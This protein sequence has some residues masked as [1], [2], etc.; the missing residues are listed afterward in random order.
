MRRH[1]IVTHVSI[2]GKGSCPPTRERESESER[3]GGG[4]GESEGES[5][6]ADVM[7]VGVAVLLAARVG[8]LDRLP[9]PVSMETE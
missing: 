7:P 6:R 2:R 5:P 8:R 4:E 1:Q 3:E 9:A